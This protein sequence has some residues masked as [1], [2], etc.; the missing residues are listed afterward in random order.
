MSSDV[1]V[2]SPHFS[3]ATRDSNPIG[4]FVSYGAQSFAVSKVHCKGV[5]RGNS[6]EVWACTD[7]GKPVVALLPQTLASCGKVDDERMRVSRP[8]PLEVVRL[9]SAQ[10]KA[11]GWHM[12]GILTYEAAHIQEDLEQPESIFFEFLICECE[13][14]P[15]STLFAKSN[16]DA[17]R[18]V[19]RPAALLK[20]DTSAKFHA[21][22]EQAEEHFRAGDIFEI[23]LSRRFRFEVDPL[24]M[25]SF[26]AGTMEHKLA[27]YRFALDFARTSVLGASPELLVK[28]E[29]PNVTTRPIS[30]SIRRS[31]SEPSLTLE[32]AELFAELLRSEKEK[33]EL[34]ML[35]DLARHDLHRVCDD[36]TV[37]RYRE[38]L[39]LETVAHTQATVEGTLKPDFNA[40][41]ALFSCLNAGTLVGAP[42][43]MAMKIIANLEQEPRNFYGGN[44]VHVFPDGNLRATIL[45]RTAVIQENTLTIQAG[46]TCLLE[47]AVD[48]EFWECGAKAR[49][50]LAEIGHEHL[51]FG[52]GVPPPIVNQRTVSDL[53]GKK[54]LVSFG[55]P[56]FGA[57]A[58]SLLLVDNED[59]FTF[60]LAALFESLGCR[61]H[62]VRNNLPVPDLTKFSGVILS[63]GPASPREAGFLL[64]YVRAC[65]GKTPVFGVCLGFQAM[66]EALGGSLGKMPAPLHGK[67]RSVQ[68]LQESAFFKGLPTVFSAARYHSLYA[69]KMPPVLKLTAQDEL[70]VPLALEGPPE[71]PAFFGVQF[72]PESFLTGE[73]GLVMARNWLALLK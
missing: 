71:W 53:A 58:H 4:G 42:K 7:E 20:D 49:S 46:A 16:P 18:K 69:L 17:I 19:V 28:V 51:C 13:P 40:I 11:H 3:L 59:S 56:A 26:L 14:T 27:P 8:S 39:V 55:K 24:E 61:V 66:V 45:I 23:V 54:V 72:H 43:K 70:G 6:L 15:T 48:Y 1:G 62:V 44:L 73:A 65:A 5:A 47:S 60:N 33:S 35:I 32:E 12:L 9:V 63:P 21:A 34:D 52:K 2:S 41:D 57:H 10:A 38:A 30:G 68:I 25:R 29:G 36:V 64:D 37:S 22:F 67:S 31:S 50:L